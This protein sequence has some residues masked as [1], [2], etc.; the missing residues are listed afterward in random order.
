MTYKPLETNF[1]FKNFRH[2][3]LKREGDVALFQKTSEP[4]NHSPEAFEAGYEVVVVGR[5]EAGEIFGNI[6]EASETYPSNEQWGIKGWTYTN[7]KDAEKRFSK[8]TKTNTKPMANEAE[9]T[10]IETEPVV[11]LNEVKKLKPVSINLPDKEF[12]MQELMVF[13]NSG[14]SKAYFALQDLIQ[15]GTVVEIRRESKGK[16][17][18]TVIYSKAG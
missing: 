5:R 8:L 3:Q 14:R 16:G 18:A 1:T 12:T 4:G 10:P 9:P 6:V 7:L 11:T 15:N 2:I 17:R 13:N